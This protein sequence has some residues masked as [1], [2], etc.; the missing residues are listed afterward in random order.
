MTVERLGRM[1]PLSS[2][3]MSSVVAERSISSTWPHLELDAAHFE[4]R[5]QQVANLPVCQ[6]L[7]KKE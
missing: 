4:S 1:L 3:E 7:R 2:D 6:P 5:A